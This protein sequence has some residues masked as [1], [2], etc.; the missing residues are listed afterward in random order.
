MIE[1]RAE[2][3]ILFHLPPSHTTPT[4]A[5][6]I[7]LLT[8]YIHHTVYIL[9]MLIALSTHQTYV[10]SLAAFLELPTFMLAL[11]NLAP[12]YFR[13][14]LVFAIVFFVTRIAF[15]SW[16]CYAFLREKLRQPDRRVEGAVGWE[17]CGLLC[18]ALPLCVPFFTSPLSAFPRTCDSSA[19]A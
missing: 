18:L 2:R 15:H 8:G 7:N 9:V 10:F 3:L 11:S 16:V 12:I 6:H 17:A 5:Q 1:Q 4:P 19:L 14:D 13:N